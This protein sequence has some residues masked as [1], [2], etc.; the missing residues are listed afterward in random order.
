MKELLE[1]LE[2]ID[3]DINYETED[4]LIDNGCLDSLSILSLVTEL[5][6]AFEIEIKP[7]DLIPTNFNSAKAMWSM[8]QRLQKED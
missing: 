4:K 2:N 3:P 7:V 8:I 1:I 5:E 6:D